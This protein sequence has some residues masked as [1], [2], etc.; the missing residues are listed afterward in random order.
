MLTI[1]L[2]KKF[3]AGYLCHAAMVSLLQD[4]WGMEGTIRHM[5]NGWVSA[6]IT[7]PVAV[8]LLIFAG[9]LCHEPK[10]AP[11][12]DEPDFLSAPKP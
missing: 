10:P 8:A 3:L 11:K 12:E 5:V 4:Y 6:W 2:S 9:W 7:V 1:S